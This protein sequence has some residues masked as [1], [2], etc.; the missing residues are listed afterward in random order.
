MKI[1]FN[2]YERISGL[3]VLTALVGSVF[4]LVLIAVQKKWFES[5]V[6]YTTKF[7]V[8]DGINPGTQVQI[9]GIKVGAVSDIYFE[10]DGKV[11]VKF[12]V[13]KTYSNRIRVDSVI[14]TFRPFIIGE[15]VLDLTMGNI[16]NP[17]LNSGAFVKAESSMDLMEIFSGRRL[18]TNMDTIDSVLKN[19]QIL[20]QAF[21]DESRTQKLINIFDK[22]E[23]LVSNLDK[24][25]K[26]FVYLSTQMSREQRMK[27]VMQNLVSVSGEMNSFLKRSPETMADVSE[28]VKNLSQITKDLNT[29]LPA[30]TAVA[31]ELPKASRQA[32]E[33]L[34]EAVIVL[35]AMQK[36]FLLSGSVKEVR[37]EERKKLEES[38]KLERAPSQE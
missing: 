16:L 17:I 27:V 37:E 20:V 31:P 13:L 18:G 36:S 8:G 26:E 23:P 15:K 35:K 2:K 30:L 9:S 5:K 33:A 28:I 14:R 24:M 34:N 10:D 29:I 32:I 6:Y 7:E 19:I 22:V 25:S 12:F 3:F 4:I 38:Q 21:T 11:S 1:K